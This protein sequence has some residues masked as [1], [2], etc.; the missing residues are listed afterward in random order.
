MDNPENEPIKSHQEEIRREAS[1]SKLLRQTEADKPT[2]IDRAF[3][4][5]GDTLIRMGIRLKERA[6]TRL[7]ADEASGPTFLI[8]L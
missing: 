2:W 8:M 4:L 5:L 1:I 3:S 6:S 7:T